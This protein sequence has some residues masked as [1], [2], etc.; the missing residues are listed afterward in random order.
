MPVCVLALYQSA[1]LMRFVRSAIVDELP[2]EYVK[3]AYAKGLSSFNVLKNQSVDLIFLDVEMPEMTG[4]ELLENLKT[5]VSVILITSRPQYAVDAFT[6][7]HKNE[8]D[9]RRSYKCGH[10]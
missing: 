1:V 2:Q 9:T 5:Q 10:N 8:D 3:T 4:L 6:G 7:L